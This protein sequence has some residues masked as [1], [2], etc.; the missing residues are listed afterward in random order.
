MLFLKSFFLIFFLIIFKPCF[1]EET[2]ILLHSLKCSVI[3]S[4]LETI[5]QDNIKN[6]F[7]KKNETLFI[8][9]YKDEKMNI[10]KNF[11]NLNFLSKQNEFRLK[12]NK[13]EIKKNELISQ[14]EKS[15]S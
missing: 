10:S 6:S 5:Y 2:E 9:V 1:S 7:F 13:K 11:N 4:E 8:Q 3:F 15:F 12:I 14:T